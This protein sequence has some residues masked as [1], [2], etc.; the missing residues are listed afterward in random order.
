MYSYT[1]P[2][3]SY[4]ALLVN[5]SLLSVCVCGGGVD[6]EAVAYEFY[7]WLMALYGRLS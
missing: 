4:H 2:F 5:F 1:A 6:P 3:P 7:G